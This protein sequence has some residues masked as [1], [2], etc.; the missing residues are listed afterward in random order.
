MEPTVRRF[1][2]SG[3]RLRAFVAI[4]ALLALSSIASAAPEEGRGGTAFDH[5]EHADLE[6]NPVKACDQCHS[7]SPEGELVRPGSRGHQPCLTADCHAKD[8]LSVGPRTRRGTPVRYQEASDFCFGCHLDTGR[9]PSPFMKAQADNLFQ[10][11]E[12][13]HY[14]EMNH[15]AHAKL[16]E[17][18]DCH[19]VDPKSFE[20]QLEGPQHAQ[21]ATCHKKGE[22]DITMNDCGDCH[23]DGAPSAYFKKRPFGTDVR[24]CNSAR[25]RALMKKR[26]PGRR[27]AACFKHERTEHRFDRKGQGIQ[28]GTCH[29][30]YKH[31]RYRRHDYQSLRDVKMAPLIDNH[32]DRAHDNCG[33]AGCHKREVD[34]SLGTGR[35]S[36]CHS[37]K[38]IFEGFL[39]EEAAAPPAPKPAPKPTPAPIPESAPLPQ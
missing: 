21:C 29:F 39:E 24:S 34:D 2:G 35:C 5:E 18:R 13:M 25:Y 4:V 16:G 7:S 36:M 6:E 38:E 31:K 33:A 37:S 23:Q 14:V 27:A 22:E 1:A 10:N 30:M 15:L 32:R 9:A 20:L 11:M 3:V 12:P 19:Q 28:C 26:R 17:C 8:F